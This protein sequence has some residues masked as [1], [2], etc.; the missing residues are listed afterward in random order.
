MIMLAPRVVVV[1]MLEQIGPLVMLNLEMP[2]I[3]PEWMHLK[4]GAKSARKGTSLTTT[5]KMPNQS[6]GG[7]LNLRPARDLPRHWV[8][9]TLVPRGDAQRAQMAILMMFILKIL[10]QVERWVA[11]QT[12]ILTLLH[13]VV[14]LFR[15]RF[16]QSWSKKAWWIWI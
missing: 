9:G 5:L 2:P 16:R 12:Q 7:L 14:R 4:E 8:S 13:L 15:Q 10:S 11:Q 3:P 1:L 6:A